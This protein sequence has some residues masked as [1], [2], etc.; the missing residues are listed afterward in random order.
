MK[1]ND[2]ALLLGRILLVMIFLS[3]GIKKIFGFEGV[4][5]YMASKGMPATKIL[6]VGAI[7]FLIIGGLSV[8]LGFKV[9]V[10]TLMLIIFLVAATLI[11][12][13]FWAVEEAMKQKETISFMKNLGLIGGLL[14]LHGSGPGKFSIDGRST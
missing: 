5:G 14:I 2:V 11:F 7:I 9:K 13:N 6:L 1:T 8:L 10:G 4:A 12:H 3:S